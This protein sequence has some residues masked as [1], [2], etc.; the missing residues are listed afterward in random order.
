[1]GFQHENVSPSK[2]RIHQL[3]EKLNN[4]QSGLD[5]DKKARRDAFDYKILAVE[6][7]LQRNALS[8]ETKFK[9]LKDQITKLQ[10]GL[11]TERIAREILDERKSKELKL[12]ENNVALDMNVEKQNRKDNENKLVKQIDEKLFALR[13][14]LAK[15]KKIREE[16]MDRHAKELAEQIARLSDAVDAEK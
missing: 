2:L 8:E 10:E 14:D 15:E 5:D 1:M 3:S 16:V 12:V 9:L 11:A 6:E 13:I 7:K 4:L